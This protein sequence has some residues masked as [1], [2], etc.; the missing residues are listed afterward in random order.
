MS[1]ES[2]QRRYDNRMPPED[3][4][5]DVQEV[6]CPKCGE[7]MELDGDMWNCSKCG[8]GFAYDEPEPDFEEDDF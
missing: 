4:L 5:P 6:E 8:C 7:F 2:A 1:L 3:D